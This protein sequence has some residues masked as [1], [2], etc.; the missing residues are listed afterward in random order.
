MKHISLTLPTLF[1][2]ILFLSACSS[3]PSS[4]QLTP[5][6]DAN[7][8]KNQVEVNKQWLLNS[9]D[10]RAQRYLIAISSGDDVATL[11][12]ESVSTRSVIEKTLQTHWAKQGHQFTSRSINGYQIDIQ[13][14][15]LLAEV[16]QNTVSHETDINTVIKVQVKSGKTTFSKTFRSHFEEEA[17][18][19]PS[20]DSL[21]TKLNTQLSQLLN[22]IVQDPELNAKLQQL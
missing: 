13:L 2:S 9:Q 19:S 4:V 10:L 3:T 5:Q 22:Q 12:N 7:S 17:P 20:I 1:L 21:T 16:E 8:V 18:F 11:I 6:I 15:K 14:L